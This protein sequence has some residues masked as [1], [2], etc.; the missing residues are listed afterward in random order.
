MG[1]SCYGVSFH[2]CD[3]CYREWHFKVWGKHK[4]MWMNTPLWKKYTEE[5]LGFDP[6]KEKV[7]FT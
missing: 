6:S 1:S 2:L 3:N 7:V 4:D 5:W